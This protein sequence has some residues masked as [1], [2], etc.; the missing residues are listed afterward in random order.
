MYHYHHLTP[1]EREKILFLWASG[2]FI[3]Q[4]AYKLCR[5]KSTIS[6]ELRG[7]SLAKGI[8]GYSPIIAQKNMENAENLVEKSGKWKFLLI[9]ENLY[10]DALCFSTGLQRKLLGY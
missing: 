5:N 4:I 6:R 7:N 2:E 1:F 9:Y 3:S 8:M 10:I